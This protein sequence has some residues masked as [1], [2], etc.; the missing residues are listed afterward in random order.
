MSVKNPSSSVSKAL[1]EKF[2]ARFRRGNIKMRRGVRR[3]RNAA[4]VDC[5]GEIYCSL[6]DYPE[7][8]LAQRGGSTS[9]SPRQFLYAATGATRPT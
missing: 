4:P 9:P 1:G 7:C 2:R 6:Q 3:E 5:K 8:D